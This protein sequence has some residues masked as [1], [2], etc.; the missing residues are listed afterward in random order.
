[1]NQNNVTGRIL[2][3]VIFG[4]AMAFVESAVVVYLRAI[5]YPDGFSFPLKA[6]TDYKILIEVFRE[7]ATILMLLSVAVLAGRLRWEQFAYFMFSF[8][9]WDIFYYIWLKVLIGWPVSFFDWDILFLIPLPWI[10]PVVAPVSISLLML[11]F[12]IL[13]IRSF[14][15]GYEFRPKPISHVLAWAGIMLILYSFMYDTGATLHQ[16]MPKPYRYELLIIGEILF[17]G[18]FKIAYSKTAKQENIL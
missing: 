10:G 7:V 1:M 14:N 8:A 15:N 5:Y 12:S 9:V 17:I 11:I 13:I 3:L 4:I 18:A 16:Q 2:W 6:L